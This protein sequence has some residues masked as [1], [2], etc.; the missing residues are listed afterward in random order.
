M[1]VRRC[2]VRAGAAG[3]VRPGLS[4]SNEP[5]WH[6]RGGLVVVEGRG[7]SGL[8]CA[9]GLRGLREGVYACRM[10][11]KRIRAGVAGEWLRR[12]P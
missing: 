4:G 8:A 2:R 11:A 7:A 12:R 9:P 6:G 3:V 10:T 1:R 5:V